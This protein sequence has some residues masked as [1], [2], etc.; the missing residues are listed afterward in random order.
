MEVATAQIENNIRFPGQYADEETGLHYNYFR[1]YDP[2]TGRYVESDPIGMEG[3]FNTYSYV[4]GNPINASDSLGLQAAVYFGEMK[5][6]IFKEM[7][8]PIRRIQATAIATMD[9]IRCEANCLLE[10]ALPGL[11]DAAEIALKQGARRAANQAVQAG[12]KAA[13]SRLNIVVN[14]FDLGVA[15][16]CLINCE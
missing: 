16:T 3:G 2:S 14:V 7:G 12:L 15:A 1:D 5:Y 10:L 6:Y 11:A 9:C 4:A 8:A 13:A